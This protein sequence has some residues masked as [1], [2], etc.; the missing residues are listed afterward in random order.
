ML[1]APQLELPVDVAA[2]RHRERVRF[3]DTDAAGIVYYANYLRWFEAGR[4]E[5]MR[6]RDLPYHQIITGG[7]Y[8]PVVETW[9]RYHASARYDDE[10]EIVS[11]VHELRLATLLVAH[12]IVRVHDGVLLV[13]G[14]ARLA[15]VSAEGKPKRLPA[16]LRRA[17]ERAETL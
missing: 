1:R 2:H 12:H 8:L 10:I 11:W 15:C 7:S 16:Q 6:A 9:C 17:V 13:D 3:G 14:A 5:L 4:A